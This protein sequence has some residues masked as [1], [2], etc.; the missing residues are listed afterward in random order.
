MN[1]AY[2]AH[3]RL[4]T[5]RAHG[6]AI[7]KMCEE[8]ARAGHTVTLFVPAKSSVGIH[9]KD[10]FNFYSI[11]KN[12]RLVRIHSSDF[13]GIERRG[14]LSFW[15]DM[16]TFLLLLRLRH[17]ASLRA[18]DRIYTRD[19]FLSAYL[20]SHKVTLEVH[21]VPSKAYL[22][23][24]A[25]QA[26][27]YVVSI[28]NGLQKKIKT[29]TGRENVLVAPDA[30]DLEKFKNLPSKSSARASLGFPQDKKMALYAGHFYEWKGVDVFMKAATYMPDIHCVLLGGVSPDL[31]R[32]QSHKEQKN[33]QI[34]PFRERS[35][36]PVFLAAADVLVLPNTRGSEISS[37]YTSP[38]KLFE[39]M[40]SGRPIVASDLP[41]LR[42]VLSE[43]NAYL[44]SPDDAQALAKGI[45]QAT[46]ESSQSEIKAQQALNDVQ[47]YTW[48]KRA[49][50]IVTYITT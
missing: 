48:S 35:S 37:L 32:L 21:D 49:Q 34:L 5:E 26:A 40:A 38:L 9:D 2:V 13:L 10:P 14:R 1:I 46:N 29:V 30:V 17:G 31:E 22:F 3:I 50:K 19:Y 20:P 12:F 24:R 47:E 16:A 23:S 39:Y 27:K 44:V 15:A 42:E 33:V 36:V 18:A 4:P 43:R 8:F 45:E 11:E 6:Y 25:V 41:S 28:S 7:M